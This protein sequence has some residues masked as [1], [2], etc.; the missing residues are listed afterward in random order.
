MNWGL[1][2]DTPLKS[3]TSLASKPAKSL[4]GF[5]VL[6][7]GGLYQTK[8]L[9][10]ILVVSKNNPFPSLESLLSRVS[11]GDMDFVFTTLSSAQHEL[12]NASATFEYRL[13]I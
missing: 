12:I 3:E 2:E 5:F 7:L 11:N 8:L 9:A 6:L 10:N 4:L 13:V 1:I